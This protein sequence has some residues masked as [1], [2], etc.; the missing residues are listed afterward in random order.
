M[1]NKREWSTKSDRNKDQIVIQAGK[2]RSESRGV[3]ACFYSWTQAEE[4]QAPLS[5][6]IRP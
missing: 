2:R 3:A 1:V 5:H 6:T 4:A